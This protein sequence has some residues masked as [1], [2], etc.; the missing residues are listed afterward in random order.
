MP[1]LE[2]LGWDSEYVRDRTCCAWTTYS[3]TNATDEDGAVLLYV[4]VFYPDSLSI[5]CSCTGSRVWSK[6]VS[7]LGSDGCKHQRRLR[8]VLLDRGPEP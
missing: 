6:A 7:L 2:C 3:W 4:L 8:D 1:Q 5:S